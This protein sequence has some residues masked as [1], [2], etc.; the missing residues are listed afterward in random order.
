[1]SEYMYF[2]INADEL[3]DAVG[4]SIW[5]IVMATIIFGVYALLRYHIDKDL[6]GTSEATII[7]FSR[8]NVMVP[9]W[10]GLVLVYTTSQFLAAALPTTNEAAFIYAADN[11]EYV[12]SLPVEQRLFLQ[13]SSSVLTNYSVQRAENSTRKVDE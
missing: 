3:K 7:H 11:Q 2:V 1:M 12:K 6:V 10:L 5:W 13:A 4:L 8:M 9:F